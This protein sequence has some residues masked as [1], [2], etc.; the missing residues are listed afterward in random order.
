MT[1]T[2]QGLMVR[3]LTRAVARAAPRDDRYPPRPHGT[4]PTRGLRLA[5]ARTNRPWRVAVIAL[6]RSLLFVQRGIG[7][8]VAHGFVRDASA[9]P[10]FDRS[11]HAAVF[12]HAVNQ[13]AN[14]TRDKQA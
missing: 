4:Q 8:A 10:R 6:L 12:C 1:A 3:K 5:Q 9:V 7:L 13:H 2:R 14:Q 11:S